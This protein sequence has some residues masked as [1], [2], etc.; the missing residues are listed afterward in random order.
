M[1]K[2]IFLLLIFLSSSVIAISGV[3]PGSYKVNFES[4]LERNFTFDFYVDGKNYV[5]TFVEGDLAEYVKLDKEKIYDRE[6][7]VANLKLPNDL[8]FEGMEEIKIIAGGAVGYILVDFGKVNEFFVVDLRAPNVNIGDIIQI[9]FDVI[10]KIS[11][12]SISPK[13]EIFSEGNLEIPVDTFYWEDSFVSE[14]KVFYKNVGTLNYSI[15]NYLAVLKVDY[16]GQEFRYENSFSLGSQNVEI[17]DYTRE[18]KEGNVGKFEIDVK[19]LWNDKMKSLYA[20]VVVVGTDYKFVTPSVSLEPWES[21]KLE[22]FFDT[23]QVI[24]Y[25]K[26]LDIILYHDG[27][28]EHEI[29]DFTLSKK[30]DFSLLLIVLVIGCVGFFLVIKGKSV[31]NR[32]S[33]LSREID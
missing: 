5:K 21:G 2:E 6:K 14:K 29:V 7:I 8:D 13:L 30:F 11:S 3:T 24:G 22:G 27:K 26:K 19:S 16:E 31:L 17:V 15:G 28:I 1:K 23:S 32:L 25:D 12:L 20:E 18:L 10:P 9:E 33:K 4:E